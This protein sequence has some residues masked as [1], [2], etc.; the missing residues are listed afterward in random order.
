[1]PAK[2]IGLTVAGVAVGN[3][4]PRAAAAGIDKVVTFAYTKII[5]AAVV[6]VLALVVAWKYSKGR[7]F[8]IGVGAGAAALVIEEAV[9]LAGGGEWVE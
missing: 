2:E 7:T 5:V 4:A 9:K 6:L 8:M 1:M 3:L